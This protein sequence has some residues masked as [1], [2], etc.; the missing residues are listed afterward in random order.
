MG[1]LVLFVGPAGP[2]FITWTT[3]HLPCPNTS[4]LEPRSCVIKNGL[5]VQNVGSGLLAIRFIGLWPGP[6][7][8]KM[9]TNTAH[10][11]AF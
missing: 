11:F 7:S 5:V 3:K 6:D 9:T 10:M 1:I 2:N 8:N 4:A